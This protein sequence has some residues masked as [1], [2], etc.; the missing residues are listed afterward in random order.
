MSHKQKHKENSIQR[1]VAASLDEYRKQIQTL[2][3]ERDN[4]KQELIRVQRQLQELRNPIRSD[5]SIAL[6]PD[7]QSYT[8]NK[9]VNDIQVDLPQYLERLNEEQ[10]DAVKSTEGYIRVIAG[11]GSGKTRALTNRYVYLVKELGISP[12]NIL[13]ITFTNKAANEMKKRIR[14]MIGDYDMAFICT[15]HGFCVQVLRADVSHINYPKNFLILDQE[16]TESIF[17]KVYKEKGITSNECTYRRA[18]QIVHFFKKGN[19]NQY[20]E[21]LTDPD[22]EPL[23]QLYEE[24][25]KTE[26][27]IVWGYIYEQRKNFGFDFDDLILAV[28]YIFGHYSE[29]LEKWQRRLE[30]IIVDEFQDVSGNQYHLC[31]MLQGY[32][33]NLFVVGDPDQTIY[34]FRG[35]DVK[36]IL[37]FDIVFE[38]TKTIMMTQNYRSSPNVIDVS[39]N[40]I[41]HN[42]ARIKKGLIPV[43]TKD[44]QTVYNHAK[45][46]VEEAEWIADQVLRILETGVEFNDFAVLYRAHHVA[47]SIEEVFIRRKIPYTIYSGTSFYERKEIKDVLSYLR[48]LIYQDDL[49]FL[50]TVNEPSRNIGESRIN[51][52]REYAESADCSLYQS[53]LC[54]LAQEDPLLLQSKGNEY[55][56][57]IEKYRSSYEQYSLSDLLEA[58]L[59]ES[60]YGE[61]LQLQGEDERLENL[62]EL[63]QS[64]VDYENSAHEDFGLEDYLAKIALFTNSD[65]EEKNKT[66]KLMTVHSA[67]GLEFPYV[68]V[69]GLVEGIFPSS[70]IRSQSELE[71]ERRLA[72]VAFTR[73]ETALFISDSEGMNQNNTYRYPSRF[74]FDIRK[75]LLNYT[76]ELEPELITNAKIQIEKDQQRLQK[77]EIGFDIHEGSIVNHKFFKTGKI[78]SIDES[79]GV[80]KVEFDNG[81]IRHLMKNVLMPVSEDHDQSNNTDME[82]WQKTIKWIKTF[83]IF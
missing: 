19:I 57:M 75:D 27:K 44:V 40:L 14:Q 34:S 29:V 26:D 8:T 23:K 79:A 72:Y 63:K 54:L 36:Y 15:F 31:Q 43:K 13:C 37:D 69:C 30:Y 39:N 18:R 42:A 9:T 11:A 4:I 24:A 38:G 45:T 48:M 62:T 21:L 6:V 56:A 7:Q 65:Q 83:F 33:G 58:I 70:K 77:P 52:I 59:S 66:V 25:E 60:G 50:R 76:K 49:S 47:R 81:T 80:C 28:I 1:D 16:D 82:I 61:M 41:E 67:K 51:R 17:K 20:I 10:K 12:D 64:M 71:E 5:L 46:T 78:V 3:S 22:P 53:L 68:F 35:A 73:A 55:V 74:I 2:Q 32:H